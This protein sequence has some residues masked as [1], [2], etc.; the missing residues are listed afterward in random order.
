MSDLPERRYSRDSAPLSGEYLAQE[1]AFILSLP[2][3][4]RLELV[5]LS[6]HPRELLRRMP[7]EEVLL[8]IQEVGAEAAGPL[9]A[10]T[11]AEQFNLFTDI[12]IWKEEN[13]DQDRTHTWLL[14]L[15]ECGEQKILEWFQTA[16]A[17]LIVLLLK[18]FL[19]LFKT[20]PDGAPSLELPRFTLDGVYHFCCLD[21][22]VLEAFRTLLSV[23][24]LHHSKLYFA[25]VESALWADLK[26]LEQQAA[27]WRRGRLAEYGFP[28]EDEASEIYRYIAPEET[29]TLI[30]KHRLT[31]AAL[32]SEQPEPR[33]PLKLIESDEQA[34]MVRA[35]PLV[36]SERDVSFLTRGLISVANRVQVADHLPVGRLASIQASARKTAGY[37][38]IALEVLTDGSP[39]AAAGLLAEVHAEHLFRVGSS[40]IEDA[41]RQARRLMLTGWLKTLPE[42]RPLLDSPAREILEGLL[43]SQ[44]QW[45]TGGE[46]NEGY[47]DFRSLAEIELAEAMVQEIEAVGHL[48]L[49]HLGWTPERLTAVL[50]RTGRW[51]REHDLRLGTI[52]NTAAARFVL[53]GAFSAD[54]LTSGEAARFIARLQS[55]P[56]RAYGRLL[57]GLKLRDCRDEAG[58]H[59]ALLAYTERAWRRLHGELEAVDT[60]RPVD[61]R[62]IQGLMVERRSAASE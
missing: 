41:A 18:K 43:G 47:G 36:Q 2:A 29:T 46:D 49:G 30:Q 39:E 59:D 50:S 32:T 21:A 10:A 11:T 3:R 55:D 13:V 9:V 23:L 12:D 51:A 17:E 34:L 15:A 19:I 61:P 40:R 48:Y 57:Q 56:D 38:N 14:T 37:I 54:P 42:A 4:E 27:R 53:E 8:T 58:L 7:A 60:A 35:L 5:A 22:E 33:Y 28:D 31:G 1:V 25:V 44:P 45:Y 16:D 26:V 6:E 20:D 62:W 52:W 24:R